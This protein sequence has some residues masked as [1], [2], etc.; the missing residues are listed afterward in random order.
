MAAAAVPRRLRSVTQSIVQTLRALTRW[1]KTHT[2]P[3]AGYFKYPRSWFVE[4]PRLR[5]GACQ[6]D[7]IVYAW[8][9]SCC[10]PTRKGESNPEWTTDLRFEDVAEICR[11]SVQQLRQD[12]KDGHERGLFELEDAGVGRFRLRLLHANWHKLPDHQPPKP[13]P[14]DDQ[15]DET[16]EEEAEPQQVRKGTVRLL[17]SPVTLRPGKASRKIAVTTGVRDC[18][19][20]NETGFP[21][22]FDPV[23]ESGTFVTVLRQVGSPA[24]GTVVEKSFPINKQTPQT[25]S[26]LSNSIFSPP[27]SSTSV[28]IPEWQSDPSYKPLV[29]AYHSTGKS[30]S[31]SQLS[32]GHKRWKD[33]LVGEQVAAVR[34]ITDRVAFA[35]WDD[36]VYVPLPKNYLKPGGEWAVPVEA[37]RKKAGKATD[38]QMAEAVRRLNA[39]PL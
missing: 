28:V 27:P 1:D 14:I 3:V 25:E 17:K 10:R 22:S 6:G 13:Q 24:K 2:E 9:D 5:R 12:L 8:S 11:C 39:N 30:L 29:A 4:L 18:V 16:E 26:P 35:I 7:L 15:E 34:G 38:Q 20:R 21:V 31:D 33:M 19:L 37:P 32:D 23:V 36:P